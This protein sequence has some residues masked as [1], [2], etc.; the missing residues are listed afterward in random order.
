MRF[1]LEA[2]LF[3]FPGRARVHS[4]GTH[5]RVS[6][7]R[8][9]RRLLP[10]RGGISCR[11]R[12][13]KNTHRRSPLPARESSAG[14]VARHS[15]AQVHPAYPD[16]KPSRGPRGLRYSRIRSYRRREWNGKRQTAFSPWTST[17]EE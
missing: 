8:T 15:L 13:P 1:S 12:I 6:S 17:G 5:S 3:C 16:A 14:Q 10:L 11:P 2:C 7:G 9:T 4:N